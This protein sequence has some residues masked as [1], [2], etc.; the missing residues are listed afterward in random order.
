MHLTARQEEYSKS[1]VFAIA[2]CA[3]CAVSLRTVDDD[4]IDL[5]LCS[6]SLG[7]R[8]SLDVQLKCTG[9]DVRG[10]TELAFRLSR[11]NY[12]DLRLADTLVPRILIVVFVPESIETWIEITEDRMLLRHCG[13]WYSLYG[14][15]PVDSATVTVHIPRANLFDPE[16]LSGMMQRIHNQEG[17]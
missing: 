15:A 5:T 8:P 7:R 13:Y 1:V 16:T 9:Q 3:G 6:K 12:D 17:L 10:N 4:S 14:A 2:A 11:K